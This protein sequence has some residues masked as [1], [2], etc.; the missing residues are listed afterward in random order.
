M[1]ALQA[2]DYPGVKW[3]VG[4]RSADAT[5][6]D[7]E[8]AFDAGEIVR[9]WP[10]RGTLH[11]VASEDLPWMLELTAPRA[12][13][14][15]AQ[16]RAALG[17]TEAD[18]RHAK[19]LAVAALPGRSAL[20]RRAL[21]AAIEA[22]GV[23]TGGQRGYHLLWHLAQTG[24]LVLG[25]TSGREQ[26]FARLEAW[27]PRSRRLDRD[28]A[29]GELARRY[30]TSH[31]PALVEDL[32]RWSGLTVRDVRRGVDI[33]GD[34]LATLQLGGREYSVAAPAP[35][36]AGGGAGV[37]LLPGFDEYI[38]GYRDRTPMLAPEHGD[39]I[40]PGGNGMFRA[41][42][43]VDGEVVGTWRKHVAARG[44]AVE[45]EALD[46][47]RVPGDGRLAAAVARFGRYL[48]M[49]ARLKDTSAA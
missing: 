12:L 1:L 16:R 14:S 38:L 9:S 29:L 26:A 15:A 20:R 6:A 36:A 10:L 27:V 30:F 17:I 25:P 48:G 32:A 45:P 49:S 11:L 24:T 8:A 35:D 33:A 22:G 42:V 40:V 23:A 44:V 47:M 34:S 39:A 13:A 19:D 41:T 7:V 21:L 2:Q 3:S 28:E 43:V 31:G 37:L 46:G 4:L 18:T 5:E